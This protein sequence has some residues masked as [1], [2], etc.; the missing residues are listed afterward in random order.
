MYTLYNEEVG[1]R[2]ANPTYGAMNASTSPTPPYKVL[3]P[4]RFCNKC[5]GA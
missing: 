2:F 3:C 1:L 4:V 5:K